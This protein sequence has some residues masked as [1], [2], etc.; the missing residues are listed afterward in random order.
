[1]VNVAGAILSA[2]LNQ[3]RLGEVVACVTVSESENQMR[4]IGSSDPMLSVSLG[5]ERL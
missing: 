1:M 2:S 3:E 4:L 5:Y